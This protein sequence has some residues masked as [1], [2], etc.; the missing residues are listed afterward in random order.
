MSEGF[1]YLSKSKPTI[2]LGPL[3]LSSSL[4]PTIYQPPSLLAN[5]AMEF[6]I[7]LFLGNSSLYS[8]NHPSD[9]SLSINFFKSSYSNS[10]ICLLNGLYEILPPFI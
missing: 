2:S 4:I 8:I 3:W 5:D 10:E 6:A 9:T 1:L 7:F